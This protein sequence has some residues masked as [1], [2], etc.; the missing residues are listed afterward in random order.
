MRCPSDASCSD[1][2]QAADAPTGPA[3]MTTW[4]ARSTAAAAVANCAREVLC[5]PSL[6]SGAGAG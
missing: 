3:P 2:Y 6:Q 5:I 4:S 1:K